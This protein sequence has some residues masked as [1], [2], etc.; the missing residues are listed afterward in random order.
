MTLE[1]SSQVVHEGLG[2]E[3]HEHRTTFGMD[4]DRH[5]IREPAG[6]PTGTFADTDVWQ[7]LGYRS[8]SGP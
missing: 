1:E 8:P 5:A 3:V 4:A 2:H 6:S 7:A